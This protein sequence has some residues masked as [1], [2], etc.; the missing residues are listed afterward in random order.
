MPK[1]DYS[2]YGIYFITIIV[3]NRKCL[4]GEIKDQKMI[5]SDF[6]KIV[7]SEWYK[8][9][10][11]RQEL[12]L[13]EIQVMPN[14]LHAIVVISKKCSFR[15]EDKYTGGFPVETQA[16]RSLDKKQ[17]D[18][19]HVE[20]PMDISLIETQEDISH[21]ETQAD[22]SLVETHGRASL[23][24]S[25]QSK[26]YRK[27]KSLSSF[28]SG[29]KSVVTTKVDDFIDL[30]N[31]QIEKFNRKNKF[32]QSNYHDHVIR[33]KKEYWKIKNYIISNPQKWNDD[34]FFE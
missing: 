6:G 30:H 2:G 26:I 33:N 28:I 5:F 24:D 34:K 1:W 27:P 16:D 7:L 12:Y 25:N 4:L 20:T 19:S 15:P 9:F 17:E 8:S 13:D 32:W 21:V 14:H 22:I 11:M 29:F 23:Q 18:R 3:Q 10:E 31:L